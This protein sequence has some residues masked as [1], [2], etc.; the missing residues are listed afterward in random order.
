MQ[1][2]DKNYINERISKEAA[3][4]LNKGGIIGPTPNIIINI[5]SCEYDPLKDQRN[6]PRPPS[7]GMS[8]MRYK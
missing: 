4:R 1:Y 3:D 7:P 5:S 8:A 6:F 2:L